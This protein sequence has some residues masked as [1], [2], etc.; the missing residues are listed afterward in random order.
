MATVGERRQIVKENH[1]AARG[2]RT[3]FAFDLDGTVTR[4]ETLP[5]LAGELGLSEE[6]ARLTRLTMDG[7]IAF[8]ESF[9]LRFHILKEIPL[10]T[11]QGIMDTVALDPVIAGFIRSRAEDCAIVTGNLDLWVEPIIKKLGC[12]AFTSVSAWDDRE[13]LMLASILD[14]GAAVRTLRE[15]AGIFRCLRRRILP[16]PTEAS[17]DRWRR[18]SRLPITWRRTRSRFAS[19]FGCFEYQSER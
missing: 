5:I 7:H 4:E 3:I 10:A 6:M 14:K 1:L 19:S 12:R 16:Y 17:I 15:E 13:G 9:R 8:S 2:A 11:I 18:P